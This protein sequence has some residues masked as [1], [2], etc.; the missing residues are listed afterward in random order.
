MLSG[1]E[2]IAAG[3][4]SVRSTVE[5][6]LK[7]PGHCAN[8]IGPYFREIG[9][10]KAASPSFYYVPPGPWISLPVGRN[11]SHLLLLWCQDVI[12]IDQLLEFDDHRPLCCLY[13][14]ALPLSSGCLLVPFSP[15]PLHI[16]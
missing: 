6:W 8:I 16:T 5:G 10:A 2:N 7:S 13:L 3:Y 1:G 12:G 9:A 14:T 4:S 15:P 11:S